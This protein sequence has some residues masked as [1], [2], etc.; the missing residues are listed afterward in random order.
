MF[1]TPKLS[2]PISSTTYSKCALRD[3]QPMRSCIWFVQS[4][5]LHSALC[6]HLQGV[7]YNKSEYIKLKT[8]KLMKCQPTNRFQ[9]QG[10]LISNPNDFWNKK[11]VTCHLKRSGATS[12]FSALLLRR[13][14][15]MWPSHSSSDGRGT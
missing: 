5:I 14:H 9:T 1:T 12:T 8:G 15:H 3:A 6:N 11:G 7:K 4:N 13:A 10:K 2:K